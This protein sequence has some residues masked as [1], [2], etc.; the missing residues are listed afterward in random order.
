MRV[1]TILTRRYTVGLMIFVDTGAWY[2]AYAKQDACHTTAIDWLER[3]DQPLITT[4]YIVTELVTLFRA[5]GMN[6]VGLHIGQ[7]LFEEKLA[8]LERVTADDV[9]RG[10][11]AFRQFNDKGW[12]LTD[13]V[14]RVVMQRLG[15]TTAFAFDQHFYQFGTVEVVPNRLS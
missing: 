5:R 9:D 1:A 13:C 10:W 14:S 4:D 11:Q 6:A 2:A 15:I 7:L 8:I 12:S 3:N